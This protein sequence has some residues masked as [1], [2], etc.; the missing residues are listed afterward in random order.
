MA[1]EVQGKDETKLANGG[2]AFP[3]WFSVAVVVGLLVVLVAIVYGAI[4]L[5]S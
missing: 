2:G 3:F 1:E 5:F 4:Q